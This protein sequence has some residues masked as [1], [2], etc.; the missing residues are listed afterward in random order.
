MIRFHLDEH[1]DHAIA[2]GLRTRGVNVTTTAEAHLLSAPDE[3]H[4]AFARSE[5]R[6]VFTNDDDFLRLA[7]RGEPHAG[8]AYCPP[9]KR[10]IGFVVRCLCL[11]N[12]CLNPEDIMGKVEYL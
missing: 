9:G 7:A 8:I 1:V 10:P 4:L 2:R 12:D 3:A 11:M 5:G 6:V